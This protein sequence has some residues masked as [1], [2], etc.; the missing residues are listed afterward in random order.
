MTWPAWT[1]QGGTIAD[2]SFSVPQFNSVVFPPPGSEDEADSAISGRSSEIN[3]NSLPEITDE[4][5]YEDFG[6]ADVSDQGLTNR[7]LTMAALASQLQRS[8]REVTPS[9]TRHSSYGSDEI[10]GDIDGNFQG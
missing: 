9:S 7:R 10:F 4:E 5:N 8:S 1:R 6:E 2:D 3:E